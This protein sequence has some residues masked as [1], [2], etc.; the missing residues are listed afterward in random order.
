MSI[1]ALIQGNW[2]PAVVGC[3]LSLAFVGTVIWYLGL[4]TSGGESD[5]DGWTY[6]SQDR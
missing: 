4:P 2:I 5:S 3:L 6:P 1:V